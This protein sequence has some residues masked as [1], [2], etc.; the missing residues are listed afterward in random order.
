MPYGT[1]GFWYDPALAPAVPQK[2]AVVASQAFPLPDWLTRMSAPEPEPAPPLR[3]SSALGASDAPASLRDRPFDPRARQRGVLVH[4][5]I[6]RLPAIPA[7]RRAEA[8]RAFVAARAGGLDATMRAA[9]VADALKVIEDERLA[10]LFAV[11]ALAEAPVSGLV[12]VGEAGAR[13]GVTGQIDRL[14]IGADAICFADFKTSA[15]PPDPEAPLSPR[16]LTQ[17]ALYRAL[18]AQIYPDRTIRA[19]MVWTAGPQVRELPASDL[20]A[21]LRLIASPEPG[22]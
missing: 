8:A 4:A 16:Y 18:L 2:S 12:G 19:F 15:R 1:V 3:P 6:E 5:L 9:I 21:A 14:A 20:E 17:M 13:V 7:D 22:G 10:P 11:D